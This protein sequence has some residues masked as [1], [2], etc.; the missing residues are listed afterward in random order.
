MIKKGGAKF[1]GSPNELL[2]ATMGKN[3]C[4]ESDTK[5][6]ETEK[7]PLSKQDSAAYVKRLQKFLTIGMSKA[8]L[9]R[10]GNT[11]V[12]T[13]KAWL[14]GKNRVTVEGRDKLNKAIQRFL[15]SLLPSFA[16]NPDMEPIKTT[17]S[18]KPVK[19]W[20]LVQDGQILYNEKMFF[21]KKSALAH[22]T[23]S[24]PCN[25]LCEDCKRIRCIRVLITPTV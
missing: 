2:S 23:P 18:A 12:S 15:L 25:K 6:R 4:I 5:V 1:Y 22:G 9:S 24:C 14:N 17:A 20:A 21:T 13:L 19:A 10:I 8:E 7:N 3:V 16:P 11:P